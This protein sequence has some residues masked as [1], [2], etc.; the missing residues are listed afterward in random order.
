MD[1]DDEL[2]EEIETV[3]DDEIVEVF[4]TISRL[5]TEKELGDTFSLELR[6]P[7][8][9]IAILC[10]IEEE[11]INLIRDQFDKTMIHN[12]QLVS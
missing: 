8:G 7:E 6:M 2:T 1:Q 11:T 5:G 3:T 4:K 10:S 9:S 12:P